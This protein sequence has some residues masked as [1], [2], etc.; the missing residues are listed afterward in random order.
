MLEAG[1]DIDIQDNEGLT[2]LNLTY[3]HNAELIKILL[4]Y[5]PSTNTKDKDGN[6][7][8]HLMSRNVFPVTD[9]EVEES[10]NIVQS[11]IEKG[12][13]SV[14]FC[15]RHFFFQVTVQR[16]IISAKNYCQILSIKFLEI[17]E[18]SLYQI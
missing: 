3:G 12:R 4:K 15:T 16:L 10:K 6:T 14:Y 9:D 7:I 11:L 13:F 1:A 5:E 17:S 2:A 8:F 18:Y